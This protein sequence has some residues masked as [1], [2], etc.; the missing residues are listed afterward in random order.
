M[1]NRLK[2]SGGRGGGQR[3]CDIQLLISTEWVES[4]YQQEGQQDM[5]RRSW[6]KGGHTDA[7]SKRLLNLRL[8]QKFRH[9]VSKC[10]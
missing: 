2:D 4:R 9:S 7:H 6:R 10:M 3:G 8:F 5:K 1:G